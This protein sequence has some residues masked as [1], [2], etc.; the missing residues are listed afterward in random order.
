M[1]NH[2]YPTSVMETGHDILRPWVARMLM[3][4]LHVTGKVPF[5]TVF[6]HGL[7]T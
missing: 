2:F 3:L 4:G 5:K 1:Y 6:L 7:G